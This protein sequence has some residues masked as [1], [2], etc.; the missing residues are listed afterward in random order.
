[1]KILC[2]VNFLVLA[3]FLTPA[4]A[5]TNAAPALAAPPASPSA[6]TPAPAAFHPMIF[7]PPGGVTGGILPIRVGGGSRGGPMEDL[8]LTVLVPLQI[9]LTTQA[10]PSLYWYQSKPAKTLC[11]VTVTEPKNPKPLLMLKSGAATPAGIHAI[12]L[13]K[14]DIHLKPDVTYK[15]SIAVVVD[16]ANRSQDIVANGVIK[17]ITP[18]PDLAAKLAQASDADKAS[19]YAENGIWYDALQSIS[20]QIDKSPK[21]MSLRQERASL[22]D[23][24]DMKGAAMD[25]DLSSS[26]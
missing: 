9:A 15:W 8:S 12:R 3:S 25:T 7:H 14:F 20:D 19:I 16:P 11:E 1:M 22:L 17:R 18:S 21:D 6:G 10:Q 2:A 24:V 5:Q 23:Q 4:V 13:S 26:P